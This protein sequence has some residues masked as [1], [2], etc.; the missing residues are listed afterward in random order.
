MGGWCKSCAR[1]QNILLFLVRIYPRPPR[2]ILGGGEKKA[3]RLGVDA[4]TYI[5][6]PY[7]RVE[8]NQRKINK[9]PKTNAYKPKFAPY[10]FSQIL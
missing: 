2:Q 6:A 10:E 7:I 4:Q 9:A 3:V 1:L 5:S 8:Q